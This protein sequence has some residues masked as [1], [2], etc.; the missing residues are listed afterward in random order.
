MYS[1]FFCKAQNNT[2][3]NVDTFLCDYG[4]FPSFY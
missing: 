3:R 4:T 2:A 1:F